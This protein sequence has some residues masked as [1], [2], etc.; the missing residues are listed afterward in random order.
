VGDPGDGGERDNAESGDVDEDKGDVGEKESGD[1]GD[2]GDAGEKFLEVRKKGGASASALKRL[3]KG[4]ETSLAPKEGAPKRNASTTSA[5]TLSMADPSSAAS[6]KEA[7]PTSIVAPV[8]SSIEKPGPRPSHE[9]EFK[10]LT[11]KWKFSLAKYLVKG[12]IHAPKKRFSGY[13]FG[14]EKRQVS[15]KTNC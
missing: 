4:S 6:A 7:A 9:K 15:E 10:K 14:E 1:P 5:K 11:T 3:R 13:D 8:P 2:S 12:T